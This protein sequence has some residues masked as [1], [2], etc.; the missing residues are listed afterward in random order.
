MTTKMQKKY[1]LNQSEFKGGKIT[2]KYTFGNPSWHQM[3]AGHYCS[4]VMIFDHDFETHNLFLENSE[5]RNESVVFQV[6]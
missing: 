1:R 4:G 2:I 6:V 3:K 5:K